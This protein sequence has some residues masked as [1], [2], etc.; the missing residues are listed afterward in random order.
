MLAQ[1][2]HVAQPTPSEGAIMPRPGAR[3]ARATLDEPAARELARA[4]L[5][6]ACSSAV[7]ARLNV[8]NARDLLQDSRILLAEPR[9]VLLP[10]RAA[11]EG[12]SIAQAPGV[13]PSLVVEGGAA[14]APFRRTVQSLKL[15]SDSR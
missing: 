1:W 13:V 6:T 8:A 15:D 10:A 11:P 9:L 3:I 2:V 14:L 4:A 7:V 5:A 12:W